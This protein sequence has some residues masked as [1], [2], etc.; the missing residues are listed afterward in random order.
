MFKIPSSLKIFGACLPV[1]VRLRR[2]L[3]ELER[4]PVSCLLKPCAHHLITDPFF[5]NTHTH[6]HTHTHKNMEG[7][8]VKT[9]IHKPVDSIKTFW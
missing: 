1:S 6:T 7:E 5:K 3:S 4:Q 2:G 8:E 9:Y